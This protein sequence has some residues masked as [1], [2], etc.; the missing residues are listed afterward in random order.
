MIQLTINN[1]TVEVPEGRT[2]LEACREHGISIPTLC[3]HPALKPY[4][5]CRLCMVEIRQGER[6]PRLVAACTHPCEA[7][8]IAWTESEAV[9]RNRRITAELLLAG[10][11]RTP[12]VVDLAAS[13]GVSEPRFTM[14]AED[15]CILCGLCVRACNEI[16]GINAISMVNRG[17]DK[18]VSTPFEV[19]SE[20]CIGC[21]TCVLICPTGHIQLKN[22]TG[23]RPTHRFSSNGNHV[24]CQVCQDGNTGPVFVQ[25]NMELMSDDC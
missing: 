16:V 9:Q 21:G 18:K 24:H 8:V 12:E 6:P 15:S 23:Y 3:Y 19:A 25:N 2:L 5:A 10:A 7:N 14:P 1:Q 17:T 11:H 4:G 13:L 22:I 20:V